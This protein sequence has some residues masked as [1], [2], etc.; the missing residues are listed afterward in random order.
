[1]R[2]KRK[3][4]VISS[5]KLKYAYGANI[6]KVGF[7]KRNSVKLSYSIRFCACITKKLKHYMNKETAMRPNSS[8]V[9]LTI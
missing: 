2:E 8:C 9:S 1:M 6:N 7:C 5:V 4:A 3:E